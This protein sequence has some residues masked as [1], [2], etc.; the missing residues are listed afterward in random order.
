M[1]NA[2]TLI[3]LIITFSCSSSETPYTKKTYV[4]GTQ[5][6][7]IIHGLEDSL[8]ER[9]GAESLG[10]LHRI[11]SVMSNWNQHSE[12]SQLNRHSGEGPCKVSKELIHIIQKAKY[13]SRVTSGAFDVT[14]G[15]LVK[16]W[17]FHGGEPNL[18]SDSEIDKALNRVGYSN[19]L[20]DQRAGTMEL[21]EGTEIDLAGIAKGYAV[22]RCMDVL[23]AG[24]AKNALVNLGGNIKATG[25]PPGKE[26]WI[27]GVRD[28]HGGNSVV[29]SILIQDQAVATS[30]N[31]ENFIEIEGKRY[32]HII[33][34]RTG[35][36]VSEVLSVTVLAQSALAADALSTGLFVLGP[37]Q[38]EKINSTGKHGLKALFALAEKEGLNF[39]KI[40]DF[41]EKL[42]LFNR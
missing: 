21:K 11:E 10:E 29:G 5:A 37:G 22:D 18:P 41:E 16:L 42:K 38:T 7:V 34:P 1:K 20:I 26:G 6:S 39:R 12:I 40:G 31:Y 4:M 35:H 17:G 15:P 28:P 9:I 27:V 19:V 2:L 14:A 36:P 8:A 25:K 30:G 32:G 24:G 13:Y 33:D 3:L 23:K